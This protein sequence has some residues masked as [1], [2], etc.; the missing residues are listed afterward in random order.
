MNIEKFAY[1]IWPWGTETREE[2]EQAA[3]DITEVGFRCFESVKAAIYAYD[4]DLEAY[5]EVLKRNNL[6][7]VSF[8]FHLPQKEDENAFFSN[9]ENELEFVAKLGVKVLSLQAPLGHNSKENLKADLDYELNKVMRFANTAR[10]F[11]ITTCLHPHHNTRVMMENEIDYM[12]Q[13]TSAK[14]L[15]F[16]PDTAHL[17]AGECDPLVV[18]E[19]YADRVGFTHLKDFT[20][21][22]DVGSVGLASAGME[23]YTNFAELGSGSVD[24]KSVFKILE[25]AGYHGY[26][27]IELDTAPGSNKESAKN[28]YNFIKNL[29]L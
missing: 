25:N 5:N 3:K 16:V 1:A 29:S 18:I 22:A 15:S 9:L 4:M 19:R 23:V 17:I 8:Y 10:Q 28:N 7:P 20:L 27:C 6:K 11:D 21:G 26:H 24:F 14:E 12:L 2:M 13:N